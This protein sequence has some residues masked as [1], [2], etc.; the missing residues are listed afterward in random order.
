MFNTIK[1]DK[2]LVDANVFSESDVL[3][4]KLNDDFV[5]K[6][7][8]EPFEKYILYKRKIDGIG[9][10]Y[11]V[12]GMR[13]GKDVKA[14]QFFTPENVVNFMMLLADLQ[15]NDVILNPACGTARFLIYSMRYMT[16]RVSGRNVDE[17]I[18]HIRKHPTVRC[19]F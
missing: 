19:R 17:K 11:E 2:E 18:E 8:I 9:S 15:T 12:L 7:F 14:G 5:F 16:E 6:F 3:A 1:K 10:A 13:T 4:D